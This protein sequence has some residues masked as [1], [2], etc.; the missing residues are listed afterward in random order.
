M[1]LQP[2]SRVENLGPG[3]VDV[4]VDYQFLQSGVAKGGLVLYQGAAIEGLGPVRIFASERSMNV[5]YDVINGVYFDQKL[6]YQNTAQ[7]K[8]GVAYP[9]VFF[10]QE[11]FTFFYYEDGEC[12]QERAT[13]LYLSSVLTDQ[14]FY[15][16]SCSY[17]ETYN[18]QEIF[19][20]SRTD[21]P[22]VLHRHKWFSWQE[23]LLR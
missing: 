9:D 10:G 13:T 8:W 3:D 20:L 4:V 15:Q 16:L 7:E 5:V 21:E 12:E 11:G 2:N 17:D 22:Y 1:I 6:K 23:K 14:M 19:R 18:L